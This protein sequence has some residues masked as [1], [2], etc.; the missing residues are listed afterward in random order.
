MGVIRCPCILYAGRYAIANRYCADPETNDGKKK[1]HHDLP[2]VIELAVGMKVMVT[3]NVETDLDITNS[4]RG[5][6][7]DIILHLDKPPVGNEPV[8]KLKYLPSYS[9]VKLD[10]TKTTKLDG[11]EEGV[12]PV[13]VSSKSFQIL[14]LVEGKYQKCTVHWCQ[15]PMTA[16]YGFTDYQSQGQTIPY[17]LVDIASPPTGMLSLFNLYVALSRSSGWSTIRLLRD[18]DEKLFQSSHDTQLL[19]E[20]DR[21][22]RL[23][24]IMKDWWTKIKERGD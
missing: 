16:A 17:V 6:I 10:R 15:F 19:D 20:D 2:D 12:I 11:L 8:I 7:V 18:F 5:K 23:D 3:Q 4:A 21:L 22:D 1:W 24:K 14:I 13:E 9:L